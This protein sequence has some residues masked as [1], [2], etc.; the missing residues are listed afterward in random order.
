I[1]VQTSPTY[2]P[3]EAQLLATVRHVG[4]LAVNASYQVETDVYLPD[5]LQGNYYLF[6]RTDTYQQVFEVDRDNNLG[7]SQQRVQIQSQPADLLVAA[8]SGPVTVESGKKIQLNWTVTNAGSGDTITN[9][10]SDN[11]FVSTSNTFSNALF[12][13]YVPHTGLLNVGESYSATGTFTVPLALTGTL[14]FFVVTDAGARVYEGAR[15][16]NN[17][18][19][20]WRIEATRQLA[21]LQVT[22]LSGP[23]EAQAGGTLEVQ[24]TVQNK[25]NGTANASFWNDNVYLSPNDSLGPAIQLGTYRRT[26]PL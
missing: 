1:F 18:S 9:V 3:S 4:A 22:A 13:G 23:A 15:E 8:L 19:A 2:N 6:V 7:H 11:V 14:Y 24:Y 12:L 10:W 21:D 16:D 17:I 25:G 26:N 20:P 5:G